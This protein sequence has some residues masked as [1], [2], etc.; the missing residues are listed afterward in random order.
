MR[1]KLRCAPPHR[2]SPLQ[3]RR[4]VHRSSPHPPPHPSRRS[5][6]RLPPHHHCATPANPCARAQAPPRRVEILAAP[7]CPARACAAEGGGGGQGRGGGCGGTGR[8]GEDAVARNIGGDDGGVERR[9]KMRR[10][11]GRGREMVCSGQW[12][13]A[14]IFY[15]S[16]R[17]EIEKA[18]QT[19]QN[20][21]GW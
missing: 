1:R 10:T 13:R 6:S 16:Q 2:C 9:S 11:T 15:V 17:H 21:A 7:P 5:S 8:V 20:T 14:G 19:N 12:G 18:V 4:S 3:P